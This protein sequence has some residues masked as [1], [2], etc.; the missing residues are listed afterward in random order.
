MI[1]LEKGAKVLVG[2]WLDTAIGLLNLAGVVGVAQSD[3]RDRVVGGTGATG[4]WS[5]DF[6]HR[7]NRWRVHFDERCIPAMGL[8]QKGKPSYRYY[9]TLEGALKVIIR[10][11]EPACVLLREK[12]AQIAA[13]EAARRQESKER[14]GTALRARQDAMQPF[15]GAFEAIGLRREGLNEWHA[16]DGSE[17]V[18][19]LV[20]DSAAVAGTKVTLVI[21]G[22]VPLRASRVVRKI[23]AQLED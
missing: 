20:G 7:L 4:D 12:R 17:I 5:L 3:P 2:S 8:R 14:A 22:N 13:D 9:T 18:V 11:V 21:P 6:Y 16:E 23:L 10:D 19:L 1:T 15:A